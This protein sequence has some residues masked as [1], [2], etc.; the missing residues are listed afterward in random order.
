MHDRIRIIIRMW[1]RSGLSINTKSQI[2]HQNDEI[3]NTGI[4]SFLR[5]FVDITQCCTVQK[6]N[7][8]VSSFR[9]KLS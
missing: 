9:D 7:L 4:A 6:L 3:H 1:I 2:R 5:D 8:Y